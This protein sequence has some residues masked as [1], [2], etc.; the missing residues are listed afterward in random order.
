MTLMNEDT[1]IQKT[2]T[3]YLERNLGWKSAL[4]HSSETHDDVR[5]KTAPSATQSLV[6]N[7]RNIFARIRDGIE[8]RRTKTVIPSLM[9]GE[10][11]V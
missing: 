3:D 8:I 1:P 4:P 7:N 10:V 6:A 9:N 11:T 5:R 2:T